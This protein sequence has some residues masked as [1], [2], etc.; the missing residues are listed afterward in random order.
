[1]TKKYIIAIFLAGFLFSCKGY[2]DVKPKSQV[3][4][5]LLFE[6]ER[7]FIDALSG[8]Y[9]LMARRDLYAD[10]LTMS[11]LDVLAQR[12]KVPTQTSPYWDAAHYNY[13][14][15]ISKFP[16]KSTI[17]KIWL[18]SYTCIAN[19][20]NLLE[21]M[22]SRK[23]L[24]VGNNYNLIKGEAL[25]LR[26]FLHFDLLR[27]FG[28]VM[29]TDPGAKSIPYR[30]KLSKE[31]QPQLPANEVMKLIIADL[32]EAEKLLENDPLKTGAANDYFDFEPSN[33]KF[34]LNY[35]AVQATLARVYQYNNQPAE[36]YTYAK[37]V[38][39]HA[40]YSFVNSSDLA[41]SDGCKDRT[42]R[43]EH[44]FAVQV[45]NMKGYT[46]AYFAV[47]PNT[48]ENSVLTN[49]DAVINGVFENSSTDIRRANQWEF[50]TGKLMHSKF[51]QLESA[52]PASCPWPKNMVP[53]VRIS[54]MYYIAAESTTDL[55][56]ATDLMDVILFNRGLNPLSGVTDKAALQNALTKEYQK[57][58]FSEG[59]LFFY[60]KRN[61]FTTIPG[62]PIPGDKKVYVLPVPVDELTF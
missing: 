61:F 6:N 32:T 41:P 20:N 44:L 62:T 16:V 19:A 50:K 21:N 31:A 1:M 37:K 5:G 52:V 42:F 2:L 27:M 18:S 33:R 40:K 10:N 58:F 47:H 43:N 57:E 15:D 17:S 13:E 36:A 46:D 38:I 56:E 39:D 12:Y 22:E 49:D 53:L 4:E 29:S 35:Y 26:A 48:Y 23:G 51:W 60:Y 45:N 25:A 34:R 8:V 59:Q 54:E 7:G 30:T 3:K 14:S 55:Q 24:F 9:T 28:P 11:F